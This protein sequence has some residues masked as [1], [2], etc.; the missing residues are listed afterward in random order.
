MLDTIRHWTE[1]VILA[2]IMLNSIDIKLSLIIFYY[3]KEYLALNFS[4]FD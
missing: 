3:V 2:V 1:T 4:P